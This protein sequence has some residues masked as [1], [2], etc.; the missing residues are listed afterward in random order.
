MNKGKL[1]LFEGPEGGG[2][3][4]M[5][6]FFAE[7]L[8]QVGFDVVETKEPSGA[9][10]EKL[11]SV[12]SEITPEEELDLFMQDRAEH[13]KNVVIPALK[14]GKIILCDRSSPSTIAYQ[15]YG[16]GLD[17]EMVVSKDYEARQGIGF[18]LVI[19]LDVPT[20]VG[21]ARKDKDN[22]FEMESVKFH[23]LVREGYLRQALPLLHDPRRDW[24]WVTIKS[25]R[26][27]K[28]VKEYVWRE[29]QKILNFKKP[30]SN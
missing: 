21:L 19:F 9:F 14:E 20:D 5:V 17:Y 23:E 30:L 27:L 12:Q 11:L 7:R 24:K 18:D 25:N 15:C 6:K 2:K 22:R 28:E 8:R 13:F 10:R 4:T 16:R 26:P 1:I 29:L 3:S